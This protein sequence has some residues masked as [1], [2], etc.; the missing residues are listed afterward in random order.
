MIEEG[1]GEDYVS[2]YHL[3]YYS[4]GVVWYNWNYEIRNC[5][6]WQE[7]SKFVGFRIDIE[8]K[9]NKFVDSII[10]CYMFLSQRSWVEYCN[11]TPPLI[12]INPCFETRWKWVKWIQWISSENTEYN[13][14][15]HSILDFGPNTLSM[16][17]S[18]LFYLESFLFDK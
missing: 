12:P 3:K 16:S 15:F 1:L 13:F 4:F 2:L 8:I 11:S 9:I 17:I 6:F 7:L 5:F 18:S 10:K 14:S